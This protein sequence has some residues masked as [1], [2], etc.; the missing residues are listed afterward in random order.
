MMRQEDRL[1]MRQEENELRVKQEDSLEQRV[2]WNEARKL[3][4]KRGTY[5]VL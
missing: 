1:G 3:E 4:L 5:N 2:T